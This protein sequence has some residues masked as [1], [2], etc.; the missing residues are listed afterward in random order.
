MQMH[1]A[2]SI[3]SI[4][5]NEINW[6]WQINMTHF[7]CMNLWF[8]EYGQPD[9]IVSIAPKIS[10]FVTLKLINGNTHQAT[11]KRI[12]RNI[13]VLTLQ[14][15]VAKLLGDQKSN[16]KGTAALKYV[17]NEN[18]IVVEMDSLNKTLDYYSIQDGNSVIAE[19]K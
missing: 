7:I 3:F 12:S 4:L 5:Q 19:W 1:D 8:T 13:T 9:D 16:Q 18:N 11:I 14:Q 6:I 15:L 17:D 2:I 10:N